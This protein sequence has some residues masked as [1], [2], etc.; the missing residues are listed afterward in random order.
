MFGALCA[1]AMEL[2]EL[3]DLITISLDSCQQIIEDNPNVILSEA[4]LERL[5]ANC[6]SSSIREDIRNPQEDSFSVHTQISHY[7]DGKVHPDVRPDILLLIESMLERD[8]NEFLQHRKKYKYDGPSIAVELKYLHIGEGTSL[9]QKDF[10]KWKRKLNDESWLYVIVLLEAPLHPRKR[11]YYEKK[12]AQIYR[13]CNA[14]KDEC[15]DDR[16]RVYCKVLKKII[17]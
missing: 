1:F 11:D 13:Q 12:E 8:R 16:N 10:D 4:D 6:I 2:L 7:V 9:V 15:Q 5:L 14:M 3:K 17:R